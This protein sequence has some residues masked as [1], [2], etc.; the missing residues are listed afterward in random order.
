MIGT[1]SKKIRLNVKVLVL[2]CPTALALQRIDNHIVYETMLI[3][4]IFLFKP[5]FVVFIIKFFKN[6]LEAVIIFFKD[7]ILCG[8][9]QWV[10]PL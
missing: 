3:P 9:I 4:E 6:I 7:R 5:L 10:V 8:R 2:A 1:L